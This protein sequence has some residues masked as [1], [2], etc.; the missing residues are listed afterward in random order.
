[1]SGTTLKYSSCGEAW[2]R[3]PLLAELKECCSSL[4]NIKDFW[5]CLTSLALSE[6]LLYLWVKSHIRKTYHLSLLSYSTIC[7][8]PKSFPLAWAKGL[9]E[10]ESPEIWMLL[11]FKIENRFVSWF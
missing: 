11:S 2:I 4:Q 7:S 5:K 8:F 6:G 9:A 10:L 1:M 3:W